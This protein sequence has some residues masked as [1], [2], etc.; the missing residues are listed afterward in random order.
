VARPK[1]IL[2]NVI[3]LDGRLDSGVAGTVDMGL[4]YGIAAHFHADAMLS[5]SEMILTGFAGQE[6]LPEENPLAG[7]KELHPLAVPKLIVADSRAR[8]HLWR[9]L[10]SQSYWGDVIALISR[11]TPRTCLAEL[12]RAGVEYVVAGEER[13]DF[14][15][16]LEELGTLLG[17]K[18]V[19]VDSGGVLNGVLL[20][21]GL[22]DEVSVLVAPTLVGGPASGSLFVSPEAIED[23][24]PI[25]LRLVHLEKIA[26]DVL[27][28][29]YEVKR[30]PLA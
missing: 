16:A 6:E 9:L 3:S 12:D 8:I 25:P 15:L 5:G 30:A 2:F 23:I 20:R 7:T 10:R 4:Y 22:V 18:T 19:R 21:A 13:V 14:A 28:L 24:A 27:W 1:V 26:E 29:R 17:I 11:H